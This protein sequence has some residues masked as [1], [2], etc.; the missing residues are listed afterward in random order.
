MK[1]RNNTQITLRGY[2]DVA[3][4]ECLSYYETD[5]PYVL[6]A[7]PSSGKTIM[8]VDM[9]I[10]LIESGQ[11][12]RI[13]VLTH[14]T[15][16]LR[17]NFYGECLN[18][19]QPKFVSEYVDG[20]VD[21][22]ACIHVALPY[23]ENSV[24]G[25]YDV[26]IVD[27]AHHN[28]LADRVQRIK[29]A[30][31]P[32]LTVLLTGT[33]SC[34][35]ALGDIYKINVIGMNDIG[36]S[37][38]HNVG[39]KL[40]KSEYDFNINSYNRDLNLKESA[41][42]GMESTMGTINNVIYGMSKFI[43]KREGVQFDESV[44]HWSQIV[45]FFNTDKFGKT[46][47]ACQTIDQAMQVADIF[48]KNGI[49]CRASHSENDPDSEL[50]YKFKENKIN[51]LCVVGRCREGYNDPDM[52][53]MVDMTMTMNIDLIYQMYARVVRKNNNYEKEK[54]YIK[55]C[56]NVANMPEFMMSTMSAALMLSNSKYLSTYNGRNFRQLEVPQWRTEEGNN[57]EINPRLV[58]SGEVEC[59]VGCEVN[60]EGQVVTPSGDVVCNVLPEGYDLSEEGK[61]VNEDGSVYVYNPTDLEGGN[62]DENETTPR[63]ERNRRMDGDLQTDIISLFSEGIEKFSQGNDVYAT[64]TIDHCYKVM[65]GNDHLSE[66]ETFKICVDNELTSNSKYQLFRK[67]SGL[68]LHS[69]PWDMTKEKPGE[70]FQRVRDALGIDDTKLSADETFKICVNNELTSEPK[71]TSY[72][73]ES[74]L[75]LHSNP[76]D[77]TKE[78]PGEY[79]QRVRDALGIDDSSK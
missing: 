57:G 1:I 62:V 24:S 40:I 37:A 47:I 58:R 21:K 42:I 17:A 76:W 28:Y 59:P 50:I 63:R 68:N 8:S 11:A 36:M 13:L 26:L 20:Y 38:F 51:V 19:I 35:I 78:K 25:D 6:A 14:H 54:L 5:T 31:K 30:I 23:A 52:I 46:L 9:C 18:F 32:K 7:C 72:R 12:K 33:P 53:N 71:Y 15:T 22:N 61:L 69:K 10:R 65:T 16:V 27:E 56:P 2:Q 41:V 49:A 43:A 74:G 3:V 45:N 34:F 73:K 79:F 70:Y 39:F 4:N 29:D 67:E 64:T 77:M 75:N 66:E 44:N 60:E 55:V 48:T